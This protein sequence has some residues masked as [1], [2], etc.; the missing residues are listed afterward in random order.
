MVCCFSLP[1]IYFPG[2]P[3]S[4]DVAPWTNTPRDTKP[5]QLNKTFPNKRAHRSSRCARLR[6][7]SWSSPRTLG[8]F[9]WAVQFLDLNGGS[10]WHL[11]TSN[12]LLHCKNLAPALWREILPAPRTPMESRLRPRR[13]MKPLIGR[14][15]SVMNLPPMRMWRRS[16]GLT[17]LLNFLDMLEAYFWLWRRDLL[18]TWLERMLWIWKFLS[19]W[20]LMDLAHGSWGTRRPSFWRT[21]QE[22]VSYANGSL[23]KSWFALRTACFKNMCVIPAV[24][25]SKHVC[26]FISL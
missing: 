21:A 14:R 26:F 11:L 23:M 20:F 24:F 7:T 6:A 5:N 18:C 16:M 1:V 17:N 15:F 9:S 12:G 25:W 2:R 8:L 22:K 10:S 4:L 13:K 3:G 19:P